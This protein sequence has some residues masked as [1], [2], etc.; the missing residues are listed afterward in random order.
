[1]EQFILIK[2]PKV[3]TDCL[4]SRKRDKKKYQKPLLSSLNKTKPT[5]TSKSDFEWRFE[6]FKKTKHEL[7]L[8]KFVDCCLVGYGDY[9]SILVSFKIKLY[10]TT[11]FWIP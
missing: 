7:E 9:T 2:E 8:L 11:I 5:Q 1:M 10:K 3:W 6:R 4:V